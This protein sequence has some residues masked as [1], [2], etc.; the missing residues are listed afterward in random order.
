MATF[1]N[2]VPQRP[3]KPTARII[4]NGLALLCFS[5]LNGGRAEVGCLPVAEHDL[6]ITVYDSGCNVLRVDG[7][8]VNYKINGE[9]VTINPSHPGVGSLF[10]P[11]DVKDIESFRHMLN[12]DKIHAE[13][14]KGRAKIKAGNVYLGEIYIN[15]GIF[16]TEAISGQKAIIHIKDDESKQLF[17]PHR[18][19]K[20]FGADINDETVIIN[21]SSGT[22]YKTITLNRNA[23]GPYSVLIRYK[24]SDIPSTQTDFERFYDVLELPSAE[25][26]QTDLK[27][28]WT[29][30]PYRH[31][32][33]ER[34]INRCMLEEQ[35]KANL[36]ENE[37]D[38]SIIGLLENIIRAREACET[39]TKPECPENLR[40]LPDQPC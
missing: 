38:S 21:I 40:G 28:E 9:T 14:G 13:F 29:E 30:I 12:L 10:Y 1:M 7:E 32:C 4:V 39:S 34:L 23:D 16:Y 35:F 19:G 25:H 17:E 22:L 6:Y 24:C 33:E 20:V 36:L 18:V 26:R 11:N 2:T 15:N 37:A 27:F 3:T 31:P 8:L 5:K